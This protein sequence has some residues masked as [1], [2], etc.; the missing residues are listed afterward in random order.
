M[1]TD[2]FGPSVLAAFARMPDVGSRHGRRYPLYR[3]LDRFVQSRGLFHSGASKR[4]VYVVTAGPVTL[5][6]H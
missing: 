2:E 3:L 4:S 1:K 5:D 6:E